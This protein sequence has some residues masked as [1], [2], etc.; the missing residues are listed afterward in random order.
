MSL[1]ETELEKHRD[2]VA[3]MRSNKQGK[4]DQDVVAILEF[5][6]AVVGSLAARAAHQPEEHPG[7][8]RAFAEAGARMFDPSIT[9][10][11]A[12]EPVAYVHSG[13]MPN[14][15]T[16]TEKVGEALSEDLGSH[17]ATTSEGILGALKARIVELE[18]DCRGARSQAEAVRG[19]LM[20]V[21]TQLHLQVAETER[22]Q[23]EKVDRDPQD[24][25]VRVRELEAEKKM[26]EKQHAAG[27]AAMQERIDNSLRALAEMT[28]ARNLLARRNVELENVLAS[29]RGADFDGPKLQLSNFAE[30]VAVTAADLERRVHA[31][32]EVPSEGGDALLARLTKALP[33][34]PPVSAA[35]E[36]AAPILTHVGGSTSFAWIDLETYNRELIEWKD[37]LEKAEGRK[38][39]LK[40][41]TVV[42][43]EVG[44]PTKVR[45]DYTFASNVR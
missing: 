8:S 18:D 43:D 39:V 19:Q 5:L 1:F 30:D 21:Q 3:H 24:A 16:H 20:H 44:N 26:L 37:K 4:H 15:E 6:L 11:D 23:N 25:R 7:F 29:T 34:A 10:D 14:P 32:A 38:V 28:K 33:F 31:E 12:P 40:K 9:R 22:I 2:Q 35:A 36:A 42:R 41:S 27:V 45:V 17:A 13:A